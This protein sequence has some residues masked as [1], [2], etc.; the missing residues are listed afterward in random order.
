MSWNPRL[1]VVEELEQHGWTG[2]EENPLGLL[3][4]N[5]AVW[6]VTSEGGDSS[7]TEP[8]GAVVDFPSDASAELIVAAC[9]AAARQES[10]VRLADGAAETIVQ[11]LADHQVMTS[12]SARH[13]VDMCQDEAVYDA[14]I[15]LADQERLRVALASAKRR[16]KRRQPHEREGLI[17][18]LER[19]NER[20]HAYVRIANEAAQVSHRSWEKT[21]ELARLLRER[22]GQLLTRIDGLTKRLED[23]EQQLAAERCRCPEPA[24]ACEGCGDECHD[25]PAS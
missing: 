13:L 15:R 21:T 18:H 22:N 14:G 1:D 11:Y 7:L 4:R 19:E 25:K 24:T 10:R 20:V 3:R 6:G 8:G 23:L 12:V 16:A 2:D 5:G 9:L 17:F